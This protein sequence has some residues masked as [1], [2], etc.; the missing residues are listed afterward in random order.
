MQL[1]YLFLA[2][3][4]PSA[5]RIMKMLW[6]LKIFYKFAKRTE[7]IDHEIDFGKSFDIEQLCL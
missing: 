1:L 4:F 5:G 6:T 2:D 3:K 7:K